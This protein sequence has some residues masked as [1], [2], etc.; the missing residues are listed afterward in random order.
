MTRICAFLLVIAAALAACGNK[1]ILN[2]PEMPV[3]EEDAELAA[4]LV[5]SKNKAGGWL[6]RGNQPQL[7]RHSNDLEV[8]RGHDSYLPF[9]IWNFKKQVVAGA[10]IQ[11]HYNPDEVAVGVDDRYMPAGFL[12]ESNAAMPG[13]VRIATA[14]AEGVRDD[15]FMLFQ[16]IISPPGDAPLGSTVSFT[17]EIVFYNDLGK[18]IGSQTALWRFIVREW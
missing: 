9:T 4:K 13:L 10:D 2:A 3:I 7:A 15:V 1:G 18:S 14:S 5:V 11:I 12:L 6:G 17:A 16:V 8:P